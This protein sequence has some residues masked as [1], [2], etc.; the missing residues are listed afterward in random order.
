MKTL[1][2]TAAIL[3]ASTA[4]VACDAED[5]DGIASIEEV[6]RAPHELTQ[7]AAASV[8]LADVQAS[9]SSVVDQDATADGWT[10]PEPGP[11]VHPTPDALPVPI[12]DP[13]GSHTRDEEPMMACPDPEGEFIT[14]VAEDPEVCADIIVSCLPGWSNLPP[15]CGC[16]C[17][18]DPIPAT[19]PL[20]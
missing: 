12:A 1:L 15:A 13:N 10:A 8:D 2:R 7:V 14:Y 16:G 9:A 5:S 17:E 3:L 18:R 19:A 20:N 6:Q 4:I 11:T